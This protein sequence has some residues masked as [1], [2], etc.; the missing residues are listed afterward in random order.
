MFTILDFT[1]DMGSAM[2][3]KFVRSKDGTVDWQH[4][5][6]VFTSTSCRQNRMIADVRQYMLA[7][8]SYDGVT[9]VTN[10]TNDFSWLL[11]VIQNRF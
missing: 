7:H 10:N 4:E 9:A 6:G 11:I 1:E 3:N 8:L 5:R 2:Q